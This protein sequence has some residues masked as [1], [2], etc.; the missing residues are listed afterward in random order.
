MGDGTLTMTYLLT[1]LMD[2]LI[3]FRIPEYTECTT[4]GSEGI[5]VMNWSNAKEKS[6]ELTSLIISK[7]PLYKHTYLASFLMENTSICDNYSQHPSNLQ[8]WTVCIFKDYASPDNISSSAHQRG[9][10]LG[11]ACSGEIRSTSLNFVTT[12][13]IVGLFRASCSMH[14]SITSHIVSSSFCL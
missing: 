11:I 9:E 4:Q 10:S 8:A 6:Y 2:V 7:F 3:T 12:S 14:S 13:F 5:W 1:R